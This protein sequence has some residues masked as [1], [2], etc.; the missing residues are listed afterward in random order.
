MNG[1]ERKQPAGSLAV[2]LCVAGS[3]LLVEQFDDFY[4]IV[5]YGYFFFP[6]SSPKQIPK[7]HITPAYHFALSKSYL[8]R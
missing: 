5:L 4:F 2:G 3:S 1:G 6:K 7:T 8:S